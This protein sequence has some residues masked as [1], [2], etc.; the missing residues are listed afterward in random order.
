MRT[1]LAAALAATMLIAFV[2]PVFF[3]FYRL[4]IGLFWQSA[5]GKVTGKDIGYKNKAEGSRVYKLSSEDEE[6]LPLKAAVEFD[7]GDKKVKVLSHYNYDK[8]SYD[9]LFDSDSVTVLYSRTAPDKGYMITKEYKKHY[10]RVSLKLA[11]ICLCLISVEVI[12]FLYLEMY[13]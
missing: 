4:M 5:E 11:L 9:K 6:E 1:S 7:A 12:V 8:E 13:R 3:A 10:I 2:P